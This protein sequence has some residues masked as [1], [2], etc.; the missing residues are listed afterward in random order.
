MKRVRPRVLI[1]TP[2]KP[3]ADVIGRALRAMPRSLPDIE[4][5]LTDAVATR[6][7]E[8]LRYDLVIIGRDHT[9][10]PSV[11]SCFGPRSAAVGRT[12]V[13]LVGGPPNGRSLD[14]ARVPLPLSFNLLHRAV[15]AALAGEL[16]PVFETGESDPRDE[17][18][19]ASGS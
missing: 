17:R 6:R 11:G 9:E 12:P 15:E 1:L 19:P 8:T 2:E 5:A 16:P 18:A 7:L 3:L 13:L 4:V 10:G 14:A